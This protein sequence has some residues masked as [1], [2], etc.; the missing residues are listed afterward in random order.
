MAIFAGLSLV[1]TTG[2]TAQIPPG[3]YDDAEGLTGDEL[4]QA[5]EEIIDDH[6][7]LDYSDLWTYFEILDE[8]PNGKVWDIYSDDP[9]SAPAYEYTFG[10]D[11][12]GNYSG[13]GDCFNREH[14]FPQSWFDDNAPMESDLFHIYPTDGFVN[15]MRSNNAYGPVGNTSW[16][17][18]NGS[19]LGSCSLPDYSGVVF[20]PIDE[21]KGDLARSYFYMLTRYAD[22]VSGWNSDM[23]MADDFSE[24][25]RD[26]LLEWAA[27]DPVSQKEIDRNN[28]IHDYQNNRNPFI[29]H[30]EYAVHIW[31][32]ASVGQEERLASEIKVNYNGETLTVW[33][34]NKMIESMTILST[35]GQVVLSETISTTRVQL[36]LT[37]SGGV[38][39]IKVQTRD[40]ISL[41]RFVVQ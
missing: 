29:D 24:W 5:L 27:E 9:G 32:E 3:Y 15:G 39:L 21:Y 7:V 16:V 26:I 13:E 22:Q 1:I 34:G 12:C 31:N 4:R 37:L 19:R 33:S 25:A 10:S 36:A 40:Q 35:T 6:T 23:L 18:T 8:R 2:S 28:G 38:Y 11:Q 30:P 20:E 17:S 41:E 14:S